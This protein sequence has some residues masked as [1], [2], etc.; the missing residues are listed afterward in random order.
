MSIMIITISGTAGSGKS[1]IGKLLAKK[2]GYKHYS[3]G[4]LRRKM[5]DEMGLS[6]AE[7]NRLGETE[8]FTDKDADEYQK[9]LGK[10]EDDFVIDGRLSFYFIPHSVK[11]FLDADEKVRVNRIFGDFRD[12]EKFN[13]FEEA[14]DA[15]AERHASDKKRYF[16]YYQIDC[17]DKKHYDLVVDTSMNQPDHSVDTIIE[18]LKG[19]EQI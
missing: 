7:F 10:A 11:L 9:K 8:A 4:D 19:R 1:T 15:V 13:S 5:A 16:K 12:T 2:L 14:R 3:M 17:Y 18:F 6:L